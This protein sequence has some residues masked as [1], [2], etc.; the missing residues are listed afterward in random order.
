MKR[1]LDQIKVTRDELAAEAARPRPH[2]ILMAH[3]S[4]ERMRPAIGTL[5]KQMLSVGSETIIGR[6]VRMLREL[7]DCRIGLC[8][9]AGPGELAELVADLRLE[10]R[11]GPDASTATLVANMH[12]AAYKTKRPQLFL[13]AD[14]VWSRRA[15]ATVV[16]DHFPPP[17]VYGRQNQNQHTGK[18]YGELFGVRATA[19]GLAD[20]VGATMLWELV[21]GGLWGA[22]PLRQFGDD[23]WTDDV[24][25]PE[26]L[27]RTLPRL[28]ELARLE[29]EA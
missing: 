9:P 29:K 20:R 7:G 5:A 15:L 13:L 14:V 21:Q 8:A 2:V 6:T 23:D 1:E 12:A 24:D 4:G 28:A 11:N 18:P 26:D 3:G 16:N 17:V 10:L 22:V 25:T 19:A 27:E